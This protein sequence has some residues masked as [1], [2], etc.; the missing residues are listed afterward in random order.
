VEIGADEKLIPAG[1]I[2]F[3]V[4]FRASRHQVSW[5]SFRTYGPTDARFDHHHRPPHELRILA[6]GNTTDVRQGG[7][8]GGT[9]RAA[10][11]SAGARD[12]AIS[13]AG[14]CFA[15]AQSRAI[16]LHPLEEFIESSRGLHQ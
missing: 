3:R 5:R 16:G 8:R 9:L 15:R 11:D 10:L 13:A 7:K 2:F 1:A 12:A 4:Y 6:A 14:D